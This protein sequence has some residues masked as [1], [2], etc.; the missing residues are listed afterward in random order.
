MSKY[1]NTKTGEL[2]TVPPQGNGYIDP[3]IFKDRYPDIE[4]VDDDYECGSLYCYYNFGS[5]VKIVPGTYSKVDGEVLFTSEVGENDLNNAFPSSKGG[6]SFEFSKALT[7]SDIVSI[8]GIS[9]TI[10]TISKFIADING[11]V[12]ISDGFSASSYTAASG[13]YGVKLLEN[14]PGSIAEGKR[15]T[16]TVVSGSGTTLV[17]I[18]TIPSVYGYDTYSKSQ[19]KLDLEAKAD[20]IIKEYRE[21]WFAASIEGETEV[22]S[23]ITAAI[24]EIKTSLYEGKKAIDNE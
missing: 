13:F 24:S 16:P 19:K 4:I 21:A 14:C 2:S 1:L 15:I 12:S 18:T 10:G 9:F 11:T 17:N 6:I 8:N 3:D 23:A 22:C 7:G 20:A 5:S